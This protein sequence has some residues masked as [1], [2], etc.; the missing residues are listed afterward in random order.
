M[1]SAGFCHGA[2]AACARTVHLER[3][4]R[5][6]CRRNQARAGAG[7]SRHRRDLLPALAGH[8]GE[9]NRRQGRRDIRYPAPL[10][11]RLGSRRR[12]HAARFA[13]RTEAQ[14]FWAGIVSIVRLAWQKALRLPTENTV[15]PAKAGIQYAAALQLITVALE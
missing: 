9:T 14:G 6:A 1:G 3:V 2:R 13:D 8:A 5:D 10:S 15:I 4:G 7:R 11:R 12:S